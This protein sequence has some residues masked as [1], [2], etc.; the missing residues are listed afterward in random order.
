MGTEGQLSPPKFWA[1][2]KLSENL[3]LAGKKFVSKNAKFGTENIHPNF[4]KIQSQN[5]NFEHPQSFLSE[6]CT[7]CQKKLKI[8]NFLPRLL[9]LR[10]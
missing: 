8:C 9:Q 2:G 7:V 4:G 3:L 1:V 6:V 5:R 10:M